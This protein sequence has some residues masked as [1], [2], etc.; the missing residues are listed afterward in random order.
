MKKT[1]RVLISRVVQSPSGSADH[2]EVVYAD[3]KSTQDMSAVWQKL[4]NYAKNYGWAEP[5][6]FG[7]GYQAKHWPNSEYGTT[8]NGGYNN[9]NTFARALLN[10][11]P[12]SV[13]SDFPGPF[14]GNP[15]PVQVLNPRP[16]P[17][18]VGP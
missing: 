5:G 11:I 14:Q 18:Y 1:A 13:P 17:R 4:Q 8:L 10:V 3:T 2:Y 9:S 6:P 7:P 16:T 15:L 12:R